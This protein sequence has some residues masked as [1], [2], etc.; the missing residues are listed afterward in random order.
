[1]LVVVMWKVEVAF[2]GVIGSV[3]VLVLMGI[4]HST[5]VLP[6]IWVV[7]DAV[8][9][10]VLVDMLGVVFALIL[11]A[12]VVTHMV[13]L[14]RLHIVVLT[15]LLASEVTLVLKVGLMIVQVPVSLVEVSLGVV[16][17][18][19]SQGLGLFQVL[20]MSFLVRSHLFIDGP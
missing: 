4:V 11:D 14:L 18:T 12:I 8:D 19:L 20:G 5:V 13:S 3:L 9:I 15:M 6:V 7:F 16:F 17:L 2:V 1:M 10:V